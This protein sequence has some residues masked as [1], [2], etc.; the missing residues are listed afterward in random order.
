VTSSVA[1]SSARRAGSPA[2]AMQMTAQD[3][4][5][6]GWARPRP[7]ARPI[8]AAG[9]RAVL[10]RRHLRAQQGPM[11]P[12]RTGHDALQIDPP[13]EPARHR[14]LGCGSKLPRARGWLAGQHKHWMLARR[15][16]GGRQA[17]RHGG[18]HGGRQTDRQR[19][20]SESSRVESSRVGWLERERSGRGEVSLQ[21]TYPES[22]PRQP[23]A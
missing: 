2:T 9:G 12:A 4:I 14:D 1:P 5:E 19:R 10:G 18:R 8:C 11:S 7:H 23:A 21:P 15:G 13:G 22:Q 17:G 20:W 6:R 16:V 3:G